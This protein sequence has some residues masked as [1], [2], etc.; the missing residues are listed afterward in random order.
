MRRIPEKARC[1]IVPGSSSRHAS[2]TSF[3]TWFLLLLL[4]FGLAGNRGFAQM[5]NA[6]LRGTVKD[7]SGAS[8]VGAKITLSEPATGQVVRQAVT[9][10]SGD[11]EFD[12]TISQAPTHSAAIRQVLSP[13]LPRTSFWIPD[14]FDAWIRFWRLAQ[15]RRRWLSQLARLS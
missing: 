12:Q 7:N 4:V 9:S 11:Y 5:V 14:K 2:R 15:R 10:A 3:T 8:V 1:S 13:F 6:T